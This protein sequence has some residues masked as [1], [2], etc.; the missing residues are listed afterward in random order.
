MPVEKYIKN[1]HKLALMPFA[2]VYATLMELIDAGVVEQAN[3]KEGGE[4]DVELP[5]SESTGQVGR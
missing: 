2:T 3:L 5:Q 1:N 4:R